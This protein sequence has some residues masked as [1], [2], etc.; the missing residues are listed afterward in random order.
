MSAPISQEESRSPGP[1]L[2]PAFAARRRR[3]V[4]A[5]A[6]L[7][8]EAPYAEVHMDA[9]AA[10]AAVAKPTLYRYFPTKERLFVEALDAT[11]SGLKAELEAVRAGAGSAEARLR[12]MIALVLSRV[13][14]LAPA[15]Q[16]SES[17]SRESAAD[18]RRVLRQGFR[19][20]REAIGGVVAEGA[21][22]GAFGP[23]DPDLAALVI[24][25]GVR[26][27]AHAQVGAHELPD[28]MA[29]LFLNGL[30]NQDAPSP[31]SA[32]IAAGAFA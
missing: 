3:I 29:D 17:E 23:V 9:I 15:I 6:R 1:E 26:T 8:A 2:G 21:G 30:R 32:L 13:G 19:N 28:A 20:L 12:R 27:A 16:A 22:E 24:L 31:R 11:L 10:A 5:A 25:G 7:F 18:S 14:R 4:E